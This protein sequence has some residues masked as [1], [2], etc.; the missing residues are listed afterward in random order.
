MFS[1]LKFVALGIDPFK[2]KLSGLTFLFCLVFCL[3]FCLYIVLTF[4]L[5]L[6]DDFNRKF[7][8]EIK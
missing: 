2:F 7:V 5:L 6:C 4:Y 1:N 8:T 3:S